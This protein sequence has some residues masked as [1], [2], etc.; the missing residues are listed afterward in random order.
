MSGPGEPERDWQS[1][2]RPGP[3]PAELTERERVLAGREQTWWL[4]AA[5]VRVLAAIC[6][7]GGMLAG[8]LLTGLGLPPVWY[9]PVTLLLTGALMLSLRGR[10]RR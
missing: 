9:A 4:R 8:S 10:S 5:M 3:T 7:A 1:C 2:A 6:F